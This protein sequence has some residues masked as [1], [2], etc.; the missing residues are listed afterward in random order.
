MDIEKKLEPAHQ[1]RE[2]EREEKGYELQLTETELASVHLQ[3]N[4]VLDLQ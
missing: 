4:L 2:R 1:E 3:C